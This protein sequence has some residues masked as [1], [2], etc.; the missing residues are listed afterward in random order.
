M[1]SFSAVNYIL[2]IFNMFRLDETAA[3]SSTAL[4]F[5]VNNIEAHV[6]SVKA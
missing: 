2:L 3:Q 5:Y 1:A 4:Y 6:V